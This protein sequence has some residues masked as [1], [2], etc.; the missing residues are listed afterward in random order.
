MVVGPAGNE[1]AAAHRLR[2]RVTDLVVLVLVAGI[3]FGA[4]RAFPEAW[5]KKWFATNLAIL[6]TASLACRFSRPY[7]RR[8]W[9]GYALFGWAYL[10]CALYGGFGIKFDYEVQSLEIHSRMGMVF[11]LLCAIIAFWILPPPIE[12]SQRVS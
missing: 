2:W 4:F 12:T 3:A 11:G 1:H 6:T 7:W 9:M 5:H 10:V 8:F